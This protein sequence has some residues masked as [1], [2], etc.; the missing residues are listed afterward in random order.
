M[1][2]KAYLEHLVATE[3]RDG[4]PPALLEQERREAR[5]AVLEHDVQRLRMKGFL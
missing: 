2:A 1:D 3:E 4:I 5:A